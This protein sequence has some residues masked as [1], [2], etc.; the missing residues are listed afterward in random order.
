MDVE[1]WHMVG[2]LGVACLLGGLLGIERDVTGHVAG[3]RTHML[4]SLGSA[5]F[6]LVSVS[7]FG[8]FIASDA[9]TVQVDPSRIASYVA[10]GVGFIGGG[11]ILKHGGNVTGLTTATSLW[12]AAAI[13]VACG[14][15]MWQPALIASGFALLSLAILHPISRALARRDGDEGRNGDSSAGHDQVGPPR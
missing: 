8:E 13:G 4:L 5:M 14:L 6:A 11:A 10:A 9:S 15:G 2:R 12:V 1:F 7:S 3:L